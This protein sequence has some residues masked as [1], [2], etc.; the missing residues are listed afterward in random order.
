[1]RP[2]ITARAGIALCLAHR[3]YLSAL[4]CASM[5]CVSLQCKCAS[6]TVCI[7]YSVC[8]LHLSTAPC[9]CILAPQRAVFLARSI[10]CFDEACLSFYVQLYMEVPCASLYYNCAPRTVYIFLQFLYFDEACIY[11]Y[12]QLYIETPCTASTESCAACS[13]PALRIC[14]G[15]AQLYRADAPWLR[16]C[17][18]YAV[19]Y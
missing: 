18:R 12:L 10:V 9:T 11:F 7:F 2:A 15:P 17:W 13:R 14:G 3:A 1:M 5:H 8:V 19:D 16:T 6:C 4:P